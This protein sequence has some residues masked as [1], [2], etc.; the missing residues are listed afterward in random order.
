LCRGRGNDPHP[1]NRR[2]KQRRLAGLDP[3]SL[4]TLRVFHLK[5]AIKPTFSAVDC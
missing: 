1:N 3:T 2:A 4:V 5:Q